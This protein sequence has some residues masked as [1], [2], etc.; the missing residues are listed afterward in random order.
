MKL[1]TSSIGGYCRLLLFCSFLSPMI[2]SKTIEPQKFKQPIPQCFVDPSC[3][4]LYEKFSKE[5]KKFVHEHV[6]SIGISPITRGF[7]PPY[8]LLA[9]FKDYLTQACLNKAI[10]VLNFEIGI[11]YHNDIG[12]LNS[13]LKVI[14]TTVNNTKPIVFI[15]M[16]EFGEEIKKII[17]TVK[18]GA[19]IISKASSSL[20]TLLFQEYARLGILDANFDG[21]GPLLK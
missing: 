16:G 1:N 9:I 7:M 13:Y 6:V 8:I 19:T 12:E 21:R 4:E 3:K 14:E 15:V 17:E 11:L 10:R 20:E 5:H 2:Y 18:P